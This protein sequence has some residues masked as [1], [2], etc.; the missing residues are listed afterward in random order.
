MIRHHPYFAELGELDAVSPDWKPVFAGLSVLRLADRFILDEERP[1]PQSAELDTCR[2]AVEGISE[3][4][5]ARAILSRIVDKLEKNSETTDDLG[6][7]LIAYGRALDLEA[8][9]PLAVDVFETVAKSFPER[10]HPRIVIE[11]ANALGAAARKTGDWTI[12]A[13][14]YTKAE[15]LAERIGDRKLR[16]STHIGMAMSNMIRGNLPAAEELLN[17]VLVEAH[18]HGIQD[19]EATALHA[20]GS[21]AHQRGDYERTIN[22]CYRSLEL[23]TNGASRDRLLSDIGAAYGALGVRDAARNAYSIV[24]LTSPH[25]WVRWQASLNLM[26]LAI[27]ECDHEGY[28]A[29][30]KILENAKFDPKL[31]TY[32]LYYSALGARKFGGANASAL[33]AEAQAYAESHELHQ[34]A[35]EIDEASRKI[36]PALSPQ[37]QPTGELL[38]IAE[39][40][41]HLRQETAA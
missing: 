9:W 14:A 15:Y 2:Q 18:E 7:D 29:Q 31:R 41:E 17:S 4:N 3:G 28:K 34:L 26:E 40:L 22:L 11:A 38:R 8:K 21:V 10:E 6:K 13:N 36:T 37:N 30:L 39:A 19:I 12:S 1:I 20:S 33:F 23:T 5:P 32:F 27:S 35:F 16:L 25:Q 24:V